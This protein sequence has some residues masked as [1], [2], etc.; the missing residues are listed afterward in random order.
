MAAC[1]FIIAGIF[2][3][4]ETQWES[5]RA[6]GWGAVAMVWLFVIHFGYSWG[7]CSWIIIAE[8]WPLSVRAIGTSLGAS[9]S[10]SLISLLGSLG[11]LLIDGIQTG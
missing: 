9:A 6:A 10:M 5:H 4:N 8:I 2:A 11:T 3:E 7:P 1:H